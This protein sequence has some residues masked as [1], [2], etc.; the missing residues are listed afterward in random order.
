MEPSDRFEALLALMDRLRDPGG[1]PWDREQDFRSLRVYLIEECFEVAEALDRQDP[2]GLCEELGDLLFQIV[3]LARLAA[4]QGSF[5]IHD[6]VRGISTKLI[7]RH[8]HVF[9]TE[10][11]DGAGDVA[12]NWERIKREERGDEHRLLD[13]VPRSLPALLAAQ[14]L[15]DKAAQVGFDWPEPLAVLDKVEEEIH[16]LRAALASGGRDTSSAELGDVLFSLVMLAR[17][18]G[19]DAE[20]ALATANRRFRARFG[21]VEEELRQRGLARADL[22]LLDQLWQQA[23]RDETDARE[24]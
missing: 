7:R 18:A 20:A 8:P 12:R 11:V 23:K 6:V 24:P 21:R 16:E 3:F 2:D 14:R 13:S 9:G 5:S 22:G 15:G 17:H 4:E 19:L 1:C 10:E